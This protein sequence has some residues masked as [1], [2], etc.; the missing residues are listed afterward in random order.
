MRYLLILSLLFMTGCTEYIILPCPKPKEITAPQ[1]QT[2][3]LPDGTPGGII[4]KTLASDLETCRQYS[5]KL[6]GSL[7]AYK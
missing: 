1:Y 6:E 5:E 7:K 2:E 3:S 4:N